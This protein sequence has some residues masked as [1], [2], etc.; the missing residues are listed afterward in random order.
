MLMAAGQAR[1][2][3]VE[4]PDRVLEHQPA[5]LLV[6][7]EIA[8]ADDARRADPQGFALDHRQRQPVLLGDHRRGAALENARLFIGDLVDR[9]AEEFGMIHRHRGDHR[10]GRRVD[11]VGRVIASA[12]ADLEQ[13]I[14][15]GDLAEHQQSRGGG[16][17][18]H[19][20]RLAGVDRLAA[21]EGG[22]HP[23]VVDE[24]AGEPDAFVEPHEMGRG[25][26]VDA[27]A[28]RLQRG[29]HE[30]DRRALAVGAGDMH[31]RRRAGLRR[32]EIGEQAF[33]A[34]ERQI[35]PLGME[36]SEARDDRILLVHA[37]IPASG[38][39][40]QGGPARLN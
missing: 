1:Q 8:A 10:D 18:E 26:D 5:V 11:D 14:I 28:R 15:G 29:A 2:R 39:A 32:A 30:G 31:H 36:R 20:N 23:L 7:R 4:Q 37:D 33:D 34:P 27:L 19:R 17:L 12:K 25:V 9:R 35:D 3:Q 24:F 40:V 6:H 13:Q 38:G 16:D 22:E 21:I